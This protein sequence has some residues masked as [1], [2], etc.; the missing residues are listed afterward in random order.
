[1]FLS[2]IKKAHRVDLGPEGLSS[3]DK[4]KY[5]LLEKSYQI[6]NESSH[7]FNYTI[8]AYVD[9]KLRNIK[10]WQK[11]AKCCCAAKHT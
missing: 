6:I 7:D 3:Y 1:M 10:T 4:K 5:D 11:A 8:Y 2:V 9:C